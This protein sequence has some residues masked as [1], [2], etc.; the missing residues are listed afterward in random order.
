MRKEIGEALREL[1]KGI[2]LGMPLSRPMP[3]VASGVHELR[4][5]GKTRAV[6]I[7]YFVKLAEVILVFRAFQKK[8]QKTPQR[9]VAIG[10]QRLKEVRHGKD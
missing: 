10:Q 5:R 8:T 1:Q 4:V 9:E 6:R 2:S 7:F 3:E